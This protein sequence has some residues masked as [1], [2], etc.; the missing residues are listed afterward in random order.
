LI[1]HS[2]LVVVLKSLEVPCQIMQIVMRIV[3]TKLPT[4]D[5]VFCTIVCAEKRSNEENKEQLTA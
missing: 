1:Q 4:Y 5:A 2:G 3:P